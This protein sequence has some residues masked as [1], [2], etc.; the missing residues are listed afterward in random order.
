MKIIANAILA[1]AVDVP[2]MGPSMA[3]GFRVTGKFFGPA[4]PGFPGD[5]ARVRGGRS[6]DSSKL[7]ANRLRVLTDIHAATNAG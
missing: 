5:V 6:W 3:A 1:G 4:N 7:N 2:S